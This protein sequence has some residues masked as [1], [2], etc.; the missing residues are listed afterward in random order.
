MAF[1]QYSSVSLVTFTVQSLGE[2]ISY[3]ELG[4]YEDEFNDSL[5]DELTDIIDPNVDMSNVVAGLESSAQLNCTLV[6]NID[7][8]CL[9]LRTVEE[10]KQ[11]TY[12]YNL[13]TQHVDCFDLGFTGRVTYSL[14]I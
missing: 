14:I 6:I 1:E 7:P 12:Y 11:R 9:C 8:G 3:V 2:S 5:V 13:S 4:W 10:L